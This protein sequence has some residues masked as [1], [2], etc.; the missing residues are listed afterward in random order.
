MTL[1]FDLDVAGYTGRRLCFVAVCEYL[2]VCK[3]SQ[4]YALILENVFEGLD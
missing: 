3:I 4:S 1:T 2:S